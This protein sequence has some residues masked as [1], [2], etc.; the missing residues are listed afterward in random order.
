M[1]PAMIEALMKQLQG[2]PT[3][4]IAQQLGSDPQTTQN[5][6][7]AALPMLMGALGSKAQQPGGL[8][9]LLGAVQGGGQQ[10]GGLN[11]GSLLGSVL[12]G[13]QQSGSGMGGVGDVLGQLLGGKQAQAEAG[14][15][16]ST[17]LNAGQAGKLL[18]M[19]APIVMAYLARQAGTSGGSGMG[20]GLVSAMLDR[21]GDGDVDVS[22]LMRVG[23]SLLKR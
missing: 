20:G 15:S 4:Q 12:G 8:D 21:D 19:L 2:G 7:G 3:G 5:A 11:V 17:G 9:A 10:G 23:S 1:N 18:Q 6:I 22:D 14:L 16:Q 13:G